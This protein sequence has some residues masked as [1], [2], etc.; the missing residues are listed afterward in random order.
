MAPLKESLSGPNDSNVV[1]GPYRRV[2]S[3]SN[4]RNVIKNTKNP[5]AI[6]CPETIKLDNLFISMVLKLYNNI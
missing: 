1:T 4:Q 5:T 6:N 2:P 3:F